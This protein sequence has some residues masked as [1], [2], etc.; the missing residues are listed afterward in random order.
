[1]VSTLASLLSRIDDPKAGSCSCS[2]RR[3]PSGLR[4]SS[5]SSDLSAEQAGPYAALQGVACCWV[6][7][8]S[9]SPSS[10]RILAR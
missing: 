4:R 3:R 5:R 8:S 6:S 1:M 7:L 2:R 9:V 10:A